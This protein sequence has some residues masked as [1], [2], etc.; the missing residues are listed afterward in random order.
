MFLDAVMESG[1]AAA[2]AAGFAALTSA[3]LDGAIAYLAET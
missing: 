3:A 2:V 1:A